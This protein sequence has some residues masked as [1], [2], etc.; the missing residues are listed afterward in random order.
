MNACNGFSRWLDTA[1]EILS[2]FEDISVE[3]SKIE[4]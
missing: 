3:T 4:K 2:E 1:E